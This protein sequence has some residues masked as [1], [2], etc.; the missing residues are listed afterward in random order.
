[1]SGQVGGGVFAPD[2]VTPK[3]WAECLLHTDPTAWGHG[4]YTQLVGTGTGTPANPSYTAD[5]AGKG[6]AMLLT[7]ADAEHF[8]A[9]VGLTSFVEFVGFRNEASNAMIIEQT[10][11]G[12]AGDGHALYSGQVATG[13]HARS[14]SLSWREI[15]TTVS[16]FADA[17][18]QRTRHECSGTHAGHKIFVADSE[19]AY[20]GATNTDDPGTAL[21][22]DTLHV[23][24]R[25]AASL[26][27]EGAFYYYLLYTPIPSA[28]FIAD[29]EGYLS[30]NY[31]LA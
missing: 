19:L 20:A 12:F 3:I 1:M 5:D 16:H 13:G 2:D 9:S 14:S 24:C 18:A 6:P 26:F 15:L 7:A 8:T 11:S 28:A 17:T 25:N 29:L 31:P 10:A 30:D 4:S 21:A 23:G 22:T 27:V